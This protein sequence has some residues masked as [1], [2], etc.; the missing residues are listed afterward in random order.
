MTDEQTQSCVVCGKPIAYGAERYANMWEASLK[1]HPC[2][3]EACTGAYSQDEHWLPGSC[4]EPIEIDEEE[5]LLE[6][7]RGRLHDGDSPRV[8]VRE[9]LLAGVSAMALRKLINQA[10][11]AAKRD[12]AT[13]RHVDFIGGFLG[14]FR[15]NFSLF[16]REGKE[17]DRFEPALE[18]LDRWEERFPQTKD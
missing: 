15:G 3:S 11:V 5:R 1:K 7:A 4:P 16:V 9:L 18:D 10:S 17:P 12:E 14:L 2:C 6:V 13:A 8:V